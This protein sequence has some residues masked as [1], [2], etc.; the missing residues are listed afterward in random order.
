MRI[1]RGSLSGK[2]IFEPIDKS[3]RP[4][5]D[6]V[7]ESIFNIIQHSQNEFVKLKG[8]K[9]LDLFSGTGSFG[10]ECLS[11]G[12]DHVVFFENFIKSLKILKKNID[13]LNLNNKSNIIEEN[14]YN[15]NQT[16]L[17]FNDFDIIFIDP[18]FKDNNLNQ[19]ILKIK[20]LKIINKKTLIIIHRN[21]KINEQ[22]SKHLIVLREKN[23]GLSKIIFGKII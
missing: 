12:S 14:A 18:P 4:L 2:K 17:I 11:R 21:K 19:L 5:K 6:M 10:I 13:Y 20:K 16:N 8:A 23:Y 9:I 7:K 1:I 15:I 3:T 22:I